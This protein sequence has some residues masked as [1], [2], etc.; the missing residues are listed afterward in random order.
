MRLMSPFK[1]IFGAALLSLAA[2]AGNAQAQTQPEHGATVGRVISSTPLVQP[3]Q[4]HPT[5]YSVVYEYAGKQYN[6][7]LPRDPGSFVQMQVTPVGA[8][9]FEQPVS[10]PPPAIQPQTVYVP[11]VQQVAYAQQ[12]VV[13]QQPYY[14]NTYVNPYLYPAIGIGLGYA[15]YRGGYFAHRNPPVVYRGGGGYRRH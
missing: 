13:Y 1:P 14:T 7:Q 15:A 3:N 12:P 9:Q 8:K 11:P 4:S 6:V 5:A 10:I 2:L